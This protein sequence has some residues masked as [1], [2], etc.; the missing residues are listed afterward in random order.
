MAQGINATK[1]GA[2]PSHE[3]IENKPGSLTN[4]G[5]TEEQKMDKVAM[6]G[7]KRATNR[8]H[9]NEETTPGNSMFTK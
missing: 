8:I 1:T 7:A 2:R 9:S 6:E 5:K 3:A 4:A